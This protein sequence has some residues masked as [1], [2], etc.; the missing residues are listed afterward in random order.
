MH[1]SAHLDVDVVAV[2]SADSVT[3]MVEIEAPSA[4]ED[5]AERPEHTAVV[6]LD[7]SGSMA[8]PRLRH[9]KRALIDLVDRLD[10]RDRFGLVVFDREAQV[11][12]P[13]GRIGDLGRDR[14]RRDI[15]A[16]QVGGMTDLSSGYL[17]GLQEARR[18]CGKAGATLVLLSDGHANSGETDPS[19]LEGVARAAGQQLITTSTIG[20][21]TGY[22]E[23]ILS[24]L[25]AGGSGNHSFAVDGDG[26]AAAVAGELDGLLSK[27]AQAASLL[28]EP[29]AGVESVSVR[30]ELPV[31]P[32]EG[33]IL[34]E[35]GDFYS[36]ER[37]KLLVGIEVPSMARL[38][39]ATVARLE[40]A[41]VQL[42]SLEQR[43][44]MI[45]I[46]VNVVPADVAKGR[47][48]D[49]KVQ[50]EKLFLDVQ[51]AKRRSEEALSLGDLATTASSLDQ[52]ATLIS[53][54]PDAV[55][56]DELRGEAD[57]LAASSGGLGEWDA[58]YSV[59]RLRAD[60]LR[61]SRGH[62]TRR[63]GGEMPSSEDDD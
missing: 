58:A 24:A 39:L 60:R 50:R 34:A 37:R 16:V 53:T 31:Q 23:R 15:A 11:A 49:A 25:A 5:S 40:L 18:V 41:C 3:V 51:E 63:Q 19:R 8:G 47:V 62:K 22:D 45:P 21:G 36:G 33:G 17:R 6:V 9:A 55:L 10:D 28:V 1:V 54:A 14:L 32:V 42:P 52:A 20:I 29:L 46:A 57:W 27:T 30:N 12:I 56:D 48:P 38:G 26:A 35:L 4:P 43:T 61:K 44:V 2:E 7:R 59:R 13:A